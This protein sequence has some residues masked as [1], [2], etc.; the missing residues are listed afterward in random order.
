MSFFDEVA[1]LLKDATVADVHVSTTG[2]K[3]KRPTLVLAPN[4]MRVLPITRPSAAAQ[5]EEP[6][7]TQAPGVGKG[8]D[9]FTVTGEVAQA[10]HDL[11]RLFG[12]DCDH[13]GAGDVGKDAP[14]FEIPF[15]VAKADADRHEI[16]GWASVV[17]KDGVLIVDKQDD[18]ITP[19]D[20]ETAAYDY[21]LHA[22]DHGFMHLEKGTGRLIESMVFT[23][24]KQAAL[25][26]DLGQIGW[27]VGFHI[28]DPDVWA[29]HKRGDLPEFSIGGRGKR[30]D[31]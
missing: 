22:R 27:W 19:G 12:A 2:G 8:D 20:L 26:I 9:G 13:D 7:K 4:Q 28:D 30:V 23:K 6:G 10:L 15:R 25:G 18:V 3:K 24:D 31:M 17:E 14:A 29:A 16:F 5:V 11:A 1:E 21:V